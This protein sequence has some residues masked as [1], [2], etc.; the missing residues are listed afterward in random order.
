MQLFETPANPCPPGA[1]L[2]T[3]RTSDGV[4]LRA[5]MWRPEGARGTV[6]LVHGRAEFIEKYYEVIGELLERGFAVATFEW[7]GQGQSQRL[8][9]N[10]AKGHVRRLGDYHKDLAAFFSQMLLPDCPPPYYA[11]AH[12]MGAAIL[13]ERASFAALS[14]A[15]LP[16]A[17]MVGVSPMLDLRTF[18]SQ[19]ALRLLALSLRLL[20]LSRAYVPGGGPKTLTQKPFANNLLTTDK[21]RFERAA[22]TIAAAPGLGLGD[23][24]INWAHVAFALMHRLARPH[25]AER[26]KLPALLIAAGDDRLTVTPTV[27]RF[28]RRLKNGACLILPHARHEVMMERPEIRAQFWAAFDAFIPGERLDVSEPENVAA[29]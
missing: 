18:G 25:A 23:P 28:A 27:E 10:A 6:A 24:T 5:A 26:I 19:Q 8:L 21:K 7:R 9:R 16:F 15:S 11:L 1:S 17:R 2:V 3:L 22:Q 12:S 29:R 20:G 13:L 4:E 14:G